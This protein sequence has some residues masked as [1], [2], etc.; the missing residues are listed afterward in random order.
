MDRLELDPRNDDQKLLAQIVHY[1]AS[2][3]K[4]SPEALAYLHGRGLS[5]G[6]LIDTFRVGYAN[7]TL[8]LRLPPKQNKAGMLIRGRL[9]EIG[10]YRDTGREHF[11]GC[12]VFPVLAADGT[13]QIV[14]LYGRKTNNH[15]RK[16]T[17]LDML[18]G[19]QRRGVWNVE[20]FASND[21]IV[22]C[23]SIFDALTFWN[24]G[25]RNVTC[26]FGPDALT[27]D[28]LAALQEFK[29]RRVLVAEEAIA[30]RVLSAG[31][32]CFRLALPRHNDV[33]AFAL[34]V[35]DP[36][37]ALGTAIRMAEW[38]GKGKAPARDVPQDE[39]AEP[40]AETLPIEEPAPAPLRTATP[41]PAPPEGLDAEVNDDEVLLSLG[42]RH[43]RVRGWTKNLSFDL[44]K[45][46][47]LVRNDA[48]MF[49]DT[50]D[51]YAAK[52]RRA[53]VAQAAQ[54][55]GVDE[56]TLKKDLG[57]VLLKL[58]ELQDVHVAQTLTPKDALPP[59]MTLEDRDE[60]LQLLRDPHLLDRIVADFDIVG[61]R[62]NK[63]VGYLAAV[64]RKLDEPLA[65]IVQSST[66]AGKTSLMDAVLALVPPEDMVKYSA[67][68]GQS[69][70]YMGE[71]DLRHKILAIVEEEGG[72]RAS[73]AL[74][75]LQSEGEL[76]IAST[77]KDSSSGRLVTQ[78][79]RVEG[80]VMIFLT[81]THIQVDEEL[82]NRCLVLTVCEDREQT[83][84][85]HQAQ[86]HKQTLNG[87]LARQ[88]RQRTRALH[89]NAQRLLR[90]MLVANPYAEALTFL[91]D[92]TR[93]RRDHVKYLTLIRTITL[94]HQHQRPVKTIEHQGQRVEY[95]EVSL[96]D[97]AVANQL[98][99]EVLG[100]SLDDLPAQTRR[101]LDL[102]AAMVSAACV[103]KAIDRVDCRFSRRDVREHT[104]W[105]HTQLKVHLRRLEEL[106]YLLVHRG[107]RGQSFVYE[108][109]FD[110]TAA[111]NGGQR[112]L[113]RLLDVEQ[114]RRNRAEANEKKSACGRPQVGLMSVD[115]RASEIAPTP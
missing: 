39:V 33:N 101:L 49:V 114:L 77:G 5:N 78:E 12:V 109:L 69:L 53:F 73:Y 42:D 112:V 88:D 40:Q 58:E 68:T 7:R 81:T 61:E 22:V 20:A 96:D 18:L 64:S 67:M 3:L 65:I 16:G 28:H 38:L 50:F 79:Y 52:H 71:T 75:L 56:P 70:F 98:A 25:Y 107:G 57:K 87:L 100:R 46:N 1:Y 99:H 89:R 59:Q 2:T 41:L 17:P 66:A 91:D 63:L 24:H 86:R 6:A 48:G 36:A 21:E 104:A 54:E 115:G 23:A 84:A 4:D 106:E 43:Y 111:N 9:Q 95:I 35:S 19:T 13:G 47:V 90:P 113:S 85:I 30:A 94:L 76:T 32:D 29:V 15:L 72:E 27:E 31:I 82:L 105:G 14:D 45:V 74:K 11:N 10:L 62:T 60:A 110:G 93:T 55:L 51:L 108:L 83:R 44:F 80:P 97:I 8:G 102:I 26:T 103:A 92:K 37:E 34:Q